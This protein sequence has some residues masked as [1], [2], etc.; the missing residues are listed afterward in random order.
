MLVD[1]AD[2]CLH[3]ES[4]PATICTSQNT[5]DN[6]SA[7][8]LDLHLASHGQC[9]GWAEKGDV[10]PTLTEIQFSELRLCFALGALGFVGPPSCGSDSV[11][12]FDGHAE[13]L[14]PLHPPRPQ[15][16]GIQYT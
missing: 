3:S 6:L 14:W 2:L 8:N 15:R 7:D 16:Y 12:V 10:S 11:S 5:H 13:G 4:V 9:F 1:G